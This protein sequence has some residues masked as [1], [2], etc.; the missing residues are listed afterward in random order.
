M[1]VD[2][3]PVEQQFGDDVSEEGT[4][5]GIVRPER[6]AEQTCQFAG[7][8]GESPCRVKPAVIMEMLQ[9]PR[10]DGRYSRVVVRRSDGL[11]QFRPHSYRSVGHRHPVRHRRPG[12][13]VR[14]AIKKGAGMSEVVH[15]SYRMLY[16]RV[17]TNSVGCAGTMLA[18]RWLPVNLHSSRLG[19]IVSA[20]RKIMNAN[21]GMPYWGSTP[22]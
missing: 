14:V 2:Q 13:E 1:P 11:G 4:V 12:D 9:R 18:M 22:Q 17:R 7:H 20:T 16:Y 3:H 8:F 10:C 19:G 21:S 5:H 6:F 15:V